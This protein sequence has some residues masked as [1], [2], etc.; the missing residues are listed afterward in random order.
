MSEDQAA[1][2]GCFEVADVHTV[3][4]QLGGVTRKEEEEEGDEVSGG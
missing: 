4:L 2:V 1:H 3:N